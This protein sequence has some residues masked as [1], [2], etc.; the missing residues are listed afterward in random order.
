[1]ILGSHDEL[2]ILIA[3]AHVMHLSTIPYI[4]TF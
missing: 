1:V 2:T 4:Q 3:Q